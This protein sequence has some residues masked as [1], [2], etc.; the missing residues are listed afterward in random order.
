MLG[1]PFV[2][3]LEQRPAPVIERDYPRPVQAGQRNARLPDFGLVALGREARA[4]VSRL[5]A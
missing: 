2:R 4:S 1:A 3:P 5:T